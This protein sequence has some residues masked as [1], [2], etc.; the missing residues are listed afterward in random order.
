MAAVSTSIPSPVGGWNARDPLDSMP[1]QDAIVLENWFPESSKVS[2]RKGYISHATGVGSGNV[3]TVMVYLGTSSKLLAASATNIYD[4]TSVGAASS[5]V[6]GKNNG[7][8]QS[9]NFGGFLVMVNGADTPMTFNGS[10]I[11]NTTY[12]HASLS[13]ATIKSVASYKGRLYF[14]ANQSAKFFYLPTGS[15]TGGAL[16]DFDL[17]QVTE[18]GGTLTAIGSWSRD[19]GDGLA[20]VIV[21]VM[22]SGEIVVYSGDDPSSATNFQKVGSFFAAEPIGDR[23]LVNLG[24]D[25]IVITKQGFI[26][27]SLLLRGGTPQDVDASNIGK[28]RQAAVDQAVATSDVF[29]WSGITD[30]G[31]NKLIV[32]VPT[33]GTTYEQY[34]W[35]ITTGAWCKF[36]NIPALHF[37]RL[38]GELYFGGASGVVYQ[39]SGTT[40]AGAAVP[41]KA[42]QAF[43]YFGDRA[44]RKRISGVR[45]VVQLDGTQDFRI[46]LDS[47]FGDRT[48]TATTHTITGLSEGGSWDTATWD[49]ADWAGAPTPNTTFLG[50]HSVGRNFALRVETFASGQNISWLASDFLGEK[51]GTI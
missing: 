8:Y 31:D 22:S 2:V 16:S 15:V 32:N 30:P 33:G 39:I 25:L 23:P 4:A 13:P 40:D 37:A 11:A 27:V 14:A 21:F 20:A 6:S 18:R 50:T 46:A 44:S 1:A 36:T 41:V 17:S 12:T 5:L 45:P 42:K 38:N 24:G 28:V 19:G 7:R 35:N 9:V 10:A 48:L 47:D 26:P 29:G 3:E 49:L 51:G 43:N 34:V